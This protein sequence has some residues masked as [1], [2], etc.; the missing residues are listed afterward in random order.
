M[1]NKS[2]KQKKDNSVEMARTDWP[3]WES[4]SDWWAKVLTPQPKDQQLKERGDG[5][6]E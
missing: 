2:K 6:D 3:F 4:L 5:D 1:T